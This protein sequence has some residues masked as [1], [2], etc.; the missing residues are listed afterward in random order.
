M[1]KLTL[2]IFGFIMLLTAATATVSAQQNTTIEEV[3]LQSNDGY[4][5]LRKLIVANFDFSN[6]NFDEGIT[7]SI[8][9]FDIAADG[10]L[11]NI[12]ADGD[13]KYVSKE[14]EDVLAG[15]HYRFSTDKEVPYTLVMPVQ[16]AIASR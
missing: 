11:Q 6:P 15:L 8:V 1:K 13:C 2:K 7:N 14:L 3:K 9:K 5:V 16:I 4:N 12:H 10:S